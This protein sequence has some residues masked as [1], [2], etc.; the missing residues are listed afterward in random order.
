MSVGCEPEEQLQETLRLY[1]EE[2]VLMSNEHRT[3]CTAYLPC[4]PPIQCAFMVGGNAAIRRSAL[5]TQ[6]PVA[7]T[8]IPEI[9]RRLSFEHRDTAYAAPF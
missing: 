6:N 3:H 8:Q 9:G 7:T 2:E 5:G 4:G 1:K